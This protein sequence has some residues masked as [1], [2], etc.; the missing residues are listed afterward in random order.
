MKDIEAA[1]V[2][3]RVAERR[4]EEADGN[5]TPEM[6]QELSVAKSRYQE[7]AT[8]H[9]TERIDALHDAE[10]RR[11]AAEPST[12]SFHEAAAE[13]KAIARE[14]WSESDQMDH[15]TRQASES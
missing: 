13:D 4:I 14:I 3:W 7:I 6:H 2:A 11:A 8:A 1:L 15:L 10:R 12:N 5:A 9:M